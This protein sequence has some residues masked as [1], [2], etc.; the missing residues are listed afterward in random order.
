[1]SCLVNTWSRPH[2]TV[3]TENCPR[4]WGFTLFHAVIAAWGLTSSP[5]PTN[6]VP[7]VYEG[8]SLENLNTTRQNEVYKHATLTLGMVAPDDEYR[9]L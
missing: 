8:G 3:Q 9:S 6:Q 2:D 7:S 4:W 5:P 1:M